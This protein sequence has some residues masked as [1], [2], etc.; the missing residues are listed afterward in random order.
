MTVDHER[1]CE[2]A[3]QEEVVFPTQGLLDRGD[4]F[5]RELRTAQSK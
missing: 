4:A 3:Q 5:H 2:E 1:S